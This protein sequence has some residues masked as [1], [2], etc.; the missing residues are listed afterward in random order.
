MRYGQRCNYLGQIG[1]V[2]AMCGRRVL[3]VTHTVLSHV[4]KQVQS[5][6]LKV[7]MEK[8]SSL[9]LACDNF[10]TTLSPH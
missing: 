4:A 8:I 9:G 1:V 7:I 2:V 6:D 10:Q 3:E 5:G